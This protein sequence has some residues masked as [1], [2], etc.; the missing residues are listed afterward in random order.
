MMPT[1]SIVILTKNA[2]ER[3]EGVLRGVEDQSYGGDVEKIV[4]DSG[5]SDGTVER[6]RSFGWDVHHIDPEE[7]HHSRPGIWGRRRRAAT[8]SSTSRTTRRPRPTTGSNGS[9]I[10]SSPTGS[11]SR[12]GGRSPTPT[13]S[14]WTSSSTRTSTPTRS[15]Y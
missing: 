4:V 13:P 6:A 8:Y 2:G 9:S 10:R 5:S 3:F 12:T 15:A 14:P 1:A 7:F 11:Q